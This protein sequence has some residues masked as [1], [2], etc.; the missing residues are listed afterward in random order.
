MF[1][2]LQTRSRTEASSIPRLRGPKATSSK[3]VGMKSW[4]SGC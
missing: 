2:A 4:S 1:K 3:T